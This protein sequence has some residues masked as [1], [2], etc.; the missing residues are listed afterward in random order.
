MRVRAW[1]GLLQHSVLREI[2][3]GRGLSVWA[4]TSWECVGAV[5]TALKSKTSRSKPGRTFLR[6]LVY[7]FLN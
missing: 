6:E 3:G 4:E 1:P 2:P 5:K 7:H